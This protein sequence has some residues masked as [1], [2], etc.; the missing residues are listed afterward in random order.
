MNEAPGQEAKRETDS[1]CL[2]TVSQMCLKMK[3]VASPLGSGACIPF[4]LISKER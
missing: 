4:A 1:V 2:W 3:V